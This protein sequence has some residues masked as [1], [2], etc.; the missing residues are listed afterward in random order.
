VTAERF[1]LVISGVLIV[2]VTLSAILIALGFFASL[3][4][5]WHGSLLGDPTTGRSSADFVDVIGELRSLRPQAIAQAGL[6]TLVATP[7]VR[8]L[9][10]LIVF[11]VERDRLYVMI[12]A[13]VLAILLTSVL[14]IH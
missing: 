3:L 5:G 1:R 11:A 14:L 7:I 10:S 4:V 13:V 8:V 2:G 6:V 12:T 9:A